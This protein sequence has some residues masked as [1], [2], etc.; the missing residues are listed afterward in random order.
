MLLYAAGISKIYS[1]RRDKA[2]GN[3][4]NLT[5]EKCTVDLFVDANDVDINNIVKQSVLLKAIEKGTSLQHEHFGPTIE[6]LRS[7]KDMGFI[8]SRVSGRIYL[9]MHAGDI[10]EA[11]SWF[12]EA[13]NYT[14][15]R[16]GRIRR[17][18]EITAEYCFAWALVKLSE[19]KLVKASDIEF[20]FGCSPEIDIGIQTKVR[21]PRDITLDR[22]GSYSVSYGD[23]DE[24]G[25]MNNTFYPDML[26]NFEDMH[27][28]RV[29]AYS[30]T[31]L[32]EARLSDSFEVMRKE[33]EDGT[34][35][36]KSALSGDAGTGV[37]AYFNFTG[38]IV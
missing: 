22:V 4:L 7:E 5:K 36:Y 26:C 9:P 20:N 19:K 8:L 23:A 6:S 32:K 29:S 21:I 13:K 3:V 25:H 38:D 31:Y 24:N 37:E 34:V 30:L 15:T 33:T 11:D 17:G 2:R 10:M 35:Y 1:A 16:Y 18:D 27:E 12:S 28:K 14:F